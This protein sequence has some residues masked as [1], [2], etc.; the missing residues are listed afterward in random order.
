VTH[1]DSLA[2]LPQGWHWA[3]LAE[4]TTRI[5]DGTH[6]PPPFSES[7]IPF[8]FVSNIVRGSI[9]FE[10]TK[11][12]SQA[13]H[14]ELNRRCPVESG[15]ILY[16]AVGSYGVAVP[17]TTDRPFSFQ[18]HIAHIKPHRE[19]SQAYL[20]HCLNSPQVLR[21]AHRDARGV[22]QKTVTLGSLSR[23]AIPLAPLGEQRRI[24]A[25]IET[26]LTRLDAAVAALQRARANLK[27][28][29]AAV[30]K[31]AVEGRLVPTEAELAGDQDNS[32]EP[33]SILLQR[34][35]RDRRAAWESRQ[36]KAIRVSAKRQ[37]ADTWKVKYDEPTQP[38]T[39]SL[40]AI[41]NGWCWASFDQL[42]FDGPQNGLYKPSSEY[43]EGLPIVKIDDY[44]DG[45]FREREALKRLRVNR[46][47]ANTYGL[48][49]GDVLINRVNSA[50][51][52]G[53]LL[54]VPPTLCPAVFE[55]NMMRL[56]LAPEIDPRF[57]SYY[58]QSRPGRTRLTAN[59]KWAVNQASINQT[60][61]RVTPIPLPPLKEQHRIVGET[62]RRLSVLDEM[63]AAVDRGLKRAE[64][65]R[66]AILKR[67]FEGK[68]VPQDPDDEPASVLLER[69]R[70]ERN[71][72]PSRTTKR[73]SRTFRRARAT[74]DETISPR[75]F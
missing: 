73:S 2:E 75:L 23:F 50:P 7:G 14:E 51:Q 53:K 54:V 28:Y 5:T 45:W 12:I 62:E 70:A 19:L 22:A 37:I 34:I 17:V 18:R 67:A 40:P 41:P 59:A 69:I 48:H 35:L 63:E 71:T 38:D 21:Q 10:R 60:D 42:I 56:S 11:F 31:A 64:R 9:S 30:L 24:A 65:V 44:Q 29:R 52:L 25:S 68:L 39:H 4:C 32:Y 20:V 46:S 26:H 15:D 3:T 43:G 74:T 49:S 6:Q 61:V 57:V 36:I 66:Q 33:G 58:I 27:R 72:M 16:S 13:T 8:I 55:S 1:P 47:E